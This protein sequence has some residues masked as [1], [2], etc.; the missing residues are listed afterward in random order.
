LTKTAIIVTSDQHINSTVGLSVPRINLDDGGS[1]NSSPGQRWLW[2]SWLE[3]NDWAQKLTEGYKRVAILN[4]DLGELDTKRR[5][6]QIITANKATIQA[7]IRETLDP[8]MLWTDSL[9]VIR[10]T[11]AHTGKSGWLEEA[12][13]A[14]YDHTVPAS[15]GVYSHYHLRLVADRVRLDIAHHAGMPSLPWTEKNAANKIAYLTRSR[16]L[17]MDAPP[18]HFVIRSHNHRTADSFDNFHTRAIC[19]PS[20]SLMTEFAYRIGAV[21][22]RSNVGGLV[23]LCE[24]GQAEVHKFSRE[25]KAGRLWA[26]QA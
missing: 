4:G 7:I 9:Y 3:F 16:Y 10:G 17:E 23:I 1:Y 21:H 12:I 2:K 15:K 18:P 8:L 24:D 11:M 13:A 22:S 25:P 14:D 19:M 26:I 5:S 6:N 20:W